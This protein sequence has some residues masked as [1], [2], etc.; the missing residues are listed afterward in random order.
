MHT[1]FNEQH[2]LRTSIWNLELVTVD[3]LSCIFICC[4]I[5]L[6]LCGNDKVVD[7][8]TGHGFIDSYS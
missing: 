2:V 5:I 6:V 4:V 8:L 1:G 7:A 3:S